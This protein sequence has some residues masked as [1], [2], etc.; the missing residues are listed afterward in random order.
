MNGTIE[1]IPSNLEIWDI[2]N[3]RDL[4]VL[5]PDG[6][7][8]INCKTRRDRVKLLKLIRRELKKNNEEIKEKLLKVLE[9]VKTYEVAK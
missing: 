1:K 9:A 5:K 7:I 6:T 4:A 3:H 2:N 8:I